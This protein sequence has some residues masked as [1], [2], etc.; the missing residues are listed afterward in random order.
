MKKY[1]S[2]A[3]LLCCFCNAFAQM[4]FGLKAGVNF[5]TL[6]GSNGFRVN[7]NGGIFDN[8]ILRKELSL[9][10]ELVYSA[11][12]STPA[13]TGGNVSNHLN[14]D[15][16]NIPILLKYKS[17][18]GFI[19]ESGPQ[20]GILLSARE[21]Y[22]SENTDQKSRFSATDFAWAFGLGYISKFNLGIDARFNLG[23]GNINK[24]PSNSFKYRNDVFQLGLVY[25]FKL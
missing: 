16:L 15:Y 14:L 12:G 25:L 24:D 21:K 23:V 22:G 1:F 8:I 13:L 20:L 11:Q 4:Q 2:I 19:A 10:P 5:A 6:A 18:S 3:V 17:H 9:Q 7:F